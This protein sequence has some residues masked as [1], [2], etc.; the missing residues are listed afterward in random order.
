MG[1]NIAPLSLMCSSYGLQ[2]L[3]VYWGPLTGIRLPVNGHQL[4]VPLTDIRLSVNGHQPFEIHPRHFPLHFN[5]LDGS[6]NETHIQTPAGDD[7]DW[8]GVGTSVNPTLVRLTGSSVRPT[9]CGST[10]PTHQ[11]LLSLHFPV[12]KQGWHRARECPAGTGRVSAL[13]SVGNPHHIL[14]S[15]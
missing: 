3:G 13:V 8:V 5:L 14:L 7:R 15:S 10:V 12:L 9:S 1:K 4:G 2:R 11:L 6:Q